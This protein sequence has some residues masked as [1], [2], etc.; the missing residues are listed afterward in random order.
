[1]NEPLSIRILSLTEIDSVHSW[2][3]TLFRSFGMDGNELDEA[4]SA[5][6]RQAVIHLD[7]H[8]DAK[9]EKRNRLRVIDGG[10]GDRSLEPSA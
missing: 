2:F 6:F 4:I 5:C 8:R 9:D 7:A 3:A 1:M 10:R